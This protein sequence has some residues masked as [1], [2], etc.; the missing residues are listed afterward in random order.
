MTLKILFWW[1]F[2]YRRFNVWG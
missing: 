2:G 1:H